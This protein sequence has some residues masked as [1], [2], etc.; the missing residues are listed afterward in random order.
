MAFDMSVL[1]PILRERE[2]KI[3]IKEIEADTRRNE[4]YSK[5]PRIREIDIELRKTPLEIVR[6][7]FTNKE[8]AEELLRGARSKNLKLQAERESL[9]VSAGY[10]KDALDVQYDCNKCN[11]TGYTSPGKACDCL[12]NEYKSTI[13]KKVAAE[14]SVSEKTF[15]A[16]DLELYSKSRGS[17]PFS[18]YDNIKRIYDFC[19]NYAKHFADSTE[20]LFFT[21]G[22]GLGKTLLASCVAVEVAASGNSVALTTAFDAVRAMEERRF[23]AIQGEDKFEKLRN[24]DLL[25]IDDL[26]AEHINSFSIATLYN[27]ITTRMTAGK[28]TIL[29]SKLTIDEIEAKYSEQFASRLRG[30]YISLSFVGEDIRG[31]KRK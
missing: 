4:I 7:T 11:D 21:G 8:K 29:I 17:L 2:E 14:F 19:V 12:L 25:V 13:I 18:P 3:N 16:F 1:R 22:T 27:L 6:A 5:I 26:G 20:N 24:C 31:K 23:A 28:K 10:S 15:A 9:L 30:E